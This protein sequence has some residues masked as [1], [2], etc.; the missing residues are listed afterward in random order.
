MKSLLRTTSLLWL[1][2]ASLLH[3]QSE[4]FLF[5]QSNVTNITGFTFAQLDTPAPQPRGPQP[6]IPVPEESQPGAPVRPGVP[7]T[8]TL[9]EPGETAN[10]IGEQNPLSVEDLESPVMTP[11]QLAAIQSEEIDLPDPFNTS[12]AAAGARTLQAAQI[13]AN[14]FII[15]GIVHTENERMVAIKPAATRGRGGRIQLL[16]LNGDKFLQIPSNPQ[17]K[18]EL[19]EIKDSSVT[20]E[21]AGTNEVVTIY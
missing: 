4:S 16:S 2:A 21:V 8:R 13:A 15:S 6:N 5:A 1:L 17:L 19:L 12:A 20:F 10:I 18:L 14:L 3:A 9:D 7:T 11:E